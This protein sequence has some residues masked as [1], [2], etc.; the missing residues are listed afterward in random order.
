M[1]RQQ[2]G[3]SVCTTTRPLRERVLVSGFTR[4]VNNKRGSGQHVHESFFPSTYNE[5]AGIR[6]QGQ[7]MSNACVL[8][9]M[10]LDQDEQDG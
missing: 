3:D 2:P 8:G 7:M 4:R 5:V 6:V 1:V 9:I 10:G